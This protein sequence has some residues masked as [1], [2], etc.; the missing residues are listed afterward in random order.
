M[1]LPRLMEGV[2]RLS[3]LRMCTSVKV[4]T[5][6]PVGAMSWPTCQMPVR[7]GA[8]QLPQ[9]ANTMSSAACRDTSPVR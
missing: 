1:T 5:G 3:S 7:V 8:S 2:A 6:V 9:L 4:M